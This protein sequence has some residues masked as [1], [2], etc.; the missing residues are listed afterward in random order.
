[1]NSLKKKAF[2]EFVEQYNRE[3][4]DAICDALGLDFDDEA[5]KAEELSFQQQCE[6]LKVPSA[7]KLY[8]VKN[9]YDVMVRI[10]FAQNYLHEEPEDFFASI[11]KQRAMGKEDEYI[12]YE[13]EDE[14]AEVI[15]AGDGVDDDDQRDTDPDWE[16]NW[17]VC[18]F[19]E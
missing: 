5:P 7:A 11:K 9:L 4:H 19:V 13:D 14:Y 1:M 3:S 2:E 10:E 16:G 6:F 8:D 18:Y 15:A 12:F 17:G